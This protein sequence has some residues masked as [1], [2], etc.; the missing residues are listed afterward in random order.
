MQKTCSG[1]LSAT[2]TGQETRSTERANRTPLSP[3][4]RMH[5]LQKL[6]FDKIG[7]KMAGIPDLN[8][9]LKILKA[10]FEPEI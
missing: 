8:S 4:K 2:K 7:I 9:M 5:D 1:T 3:V 10:L 6:E